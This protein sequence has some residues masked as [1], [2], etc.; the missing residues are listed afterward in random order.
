LAEL[1]DALGKGKS[2]DF[3]GR[4]W[5]VRPLD[6][7]DLCDLDEVLREWHPEGKPVEKIVGKR[8]IKVT[9]VAHGL[10]L[11]DI[12]KLKHQREILWLVLRKADPSLPAEYRDRCS[13]KLT[14]A[15]AGSLISGAD[16]N[17]PETGTFL[18]EIL[19]ISGL[20]P[21]LPVTVGPEAPSQGRLT[22]EADPN[23]VAPPAPTKTSASL[24]ASEGTSAS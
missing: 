13:Y 2:L 18:V 21:T 16:M 14:R 24:S 11:L 19:R 7:N 8:K 4:T 20:L 12:S 15:Q 17:K 22:E 3:A 23:A 10:E 5:D 6:F 9:E 1:S